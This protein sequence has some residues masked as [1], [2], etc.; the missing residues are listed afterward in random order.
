[1]RPYISNYDYFRG[2]GAK[3]FC[4]RYSTGTVVGD[5]K[6]YKYCL[7]CI[8]KLLLALPSTFGIYLLFTS[9]VY[10]R[11]SPYCDPYIP[12]QNVQVYTERV[13]A[14]FCTA[15]HSTAQ[16]IRIPLPY[17]YTCTRTVQ[18]LITVSKGREV[19]SQLPQLGLGH[20]NLLELQELY[21]PVP[22][23]YRYS[24][25]YVLLKCPV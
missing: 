20:T 4:W 10:T 7:Y 15:Q 1:M 24:Y 6:Q 11:Y 25:R 5:L 3:R 14:L 19:G 18:V 9:T 23:R 22:V 13:L 2:A 12:V 17:V 8:L 21:K 16:Y